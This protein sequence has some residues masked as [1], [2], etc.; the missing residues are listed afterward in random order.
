[1]PILYTNSMKYLRYIF[2]SNSNDDAEMLRQL[3]LL[4]CKSN[5]LIRLFSK[6]SKTVI[7]E[8]CR[9]FA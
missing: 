5:S 7:I 3:R 2:S 1:M 4:Y 8:L 9:N 6:C